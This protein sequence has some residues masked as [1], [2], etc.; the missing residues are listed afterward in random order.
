V[1]EE[2]AAAIEDLEKSTFDL[3]DADQDDFDAIRRALDR[4][5]SAVA[6]TAAHDL[7]KIG[8]AHLARLSAV[9]D[10]GRAAAERLSDSKRS[11]AGDLNRNSQILKALEETQDDCSPR[12]NYTA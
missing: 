6:R 10:G 7:S 4:R 11:A 5:E 8:S 3:L 1:D 9:A 2:L 12:L